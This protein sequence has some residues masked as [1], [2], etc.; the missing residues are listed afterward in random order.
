VGAITVAPHAYHE[1]LVPWFQGGGGGGGF[2]EN[3]THR[4]QPKNLQVL[5]FS[6]FLAAEYDL[7]VLYLNI[8]KK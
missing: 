6:F 8:L 5:T 4:R 2:K 3:G 1:S 7:K